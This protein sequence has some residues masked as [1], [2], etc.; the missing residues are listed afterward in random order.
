MGMDLH[1]GHRGSPDDDTFEFIRPRYSANVAGWAWLIKNAEDWGWEPAGTLPPLT[2][3]ADGRD[4][5]WSGT[6]WT[7]DGQRVTAEDAAAWAAAL[8]RGLPYPGEAGRWRELVAEFIAYC[9]G[10]GFE[11]W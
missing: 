4:W 9:R 6:Y 1:R 11:I 8:E 2:R 7:N 10:G 3:E 5:R